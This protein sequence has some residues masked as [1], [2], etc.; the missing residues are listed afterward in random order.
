MKINESKIRQE[1]KGRGL[2]LTAFAKEIGISRQL[3]YHYMKKGSTFSVAEKLG[4][5]LHVDP[6]S[7]LTS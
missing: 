6:F 5:A 4:K 3:L 7:L 2:T 1:A